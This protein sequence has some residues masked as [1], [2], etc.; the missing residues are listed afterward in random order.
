[1]NDIEGFILAGGAS[2][3]MGRDKAELRLRDKTF[4]ERAADALHKIT[5]GKISIVGNL[6]FGNLRVKL[7]SNKFSTF[8][9]IA[10]LLNSSITA[11]ALSVC[12]WLNPDV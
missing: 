9:G 5:G 11:T 10:T 3:R 2:R 8:F 6:P 1:M 7:S 4:V 12:V